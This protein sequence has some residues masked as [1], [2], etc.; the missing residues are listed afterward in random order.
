VVLAFDVLGALTAKRCGFPYANLAIPAWILYL[1]LGLGVQ[2]AL[3]DPRATAIV[4]AVAALVEA[5]AGNAIV[6]RI[7]PPRP[8]M[9]ARQLVAGS[10]VAVVSEVAIAFVGATWLFYAIVVFVSR[11]R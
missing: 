3:L 4:A 2:T 6:A 8:A 5:T 9:T 11:H 7:G 1:L 10:A